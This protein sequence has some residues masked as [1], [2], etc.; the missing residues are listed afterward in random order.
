[1]PS[2][3]VIG[4]MP[5]HGLG[6]CTAPSMLGFQCL[7]ERVSGY[8]YQPS[9][10]FEAGLSPS[11]RADGIADFFGI[12]KVGRA[13]FAFTKHAIVARILDRRIRAV[14][15]G[16]CDPGSE[17]SLRDCSWL[18]KIHDI[19]GDRDFGKGVH[20][21]DIHWRRIDCHRKSNPLSLLSRPA[22]RMSI[23]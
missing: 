2:H 3:G 13:R 17:C 1:M 12:C 23:A 8:S 16:L 6:G 10:D 19:D 21:E 11:V 18:A 22:S 14:W 7:N 20:L 15:N 5:V 9:V 4:Q